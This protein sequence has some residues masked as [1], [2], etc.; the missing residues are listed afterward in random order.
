M[1][2]SR[3]VMEQYNELLRI[4]GQFTQH[5]LNMDEAI[6]V[7]SI[8]DKLPPS[9]KDFKHML[10]HKKEELDLTQLGTHL[11]IEENLRVQEDVKPKDSS[12]VHMMEIGESSSQKK[13][14]KRS[15]EKG[16]NLSKADKNK[17]AK[18]PCWKCGKPGHFKRD[19]PMKKSKNNGNHHVGQGS[20]DHGPQCRIPTF[21]LDF[22]PNSSVNYVSLINEAYFVQDDDVAWWV[23]S[24][25]NIH[26]SKDHNGS[27][28][29]NLWNTILFSTW[30]MSQLLQSND[31]AP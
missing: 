18:P 28:L 23:D 21:D 22:D 24:G 8:I 31:M 25:A 20:N 1:S 30:A 29:T 4:Y 15:R 6:V 16:N 9:W 5:N 12:S 26:V 10:K 7:S 11:C 2:D 19:C 13:G 17:K 3:S 27:K 14:K